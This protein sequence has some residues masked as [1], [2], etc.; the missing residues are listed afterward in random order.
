MKQ[1]DK[2]LKVIMLEIN[3]LLL[4]SSGSNQSVNGVQKVEL[5]YLRILIIP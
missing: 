1:L 3:Q 5:I 2:F 4:L